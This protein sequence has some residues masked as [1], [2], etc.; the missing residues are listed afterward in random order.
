M[1]L[2]TADAMLG[3]ND[4]RSD[5]MEPLPGAPYVEFEVDCPRKGSR[6]S[7]ADALR[8][9]VQLPTSTPLLQSAPRNSIC[10]VYF[11]D[12]LCAYCRFGGHVPQSV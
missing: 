1:S 3:V 12:L 11:I 7:L 8:S 2:K 10:I 9:S 4:I 5:A 6:S